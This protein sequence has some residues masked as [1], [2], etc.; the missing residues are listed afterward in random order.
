MKRLTLL[1]PLQ[2]IAIL[3][4]FLALIFYGQDEFFKPKETE[5][6]AGKNLRPNIVTISLES[7]QINGIQTS[8]LAQTHSRLIQLGYGRVLSIDGLLD[9]RTRTLASIAEADVLQAN[10]LHSQQEYQRAS[11]L[12]AENKNV[13]DKAVESALAEMN[14]LK[15]RINTART[16][17]HSMQ[18]S[19]KQAWGEVLTDLAL[20]AAH[21]SHFQHLVNHHL[22]LVLVTLPIDQATHTNLKLSPINNLNTVYTASYLA[23]STITDT[24]LHGK[25]YFYEVRSR[26]L[27]PDMRFYVYTQQAANAHIAIPNQ[28]IV[29]H[30][31]L[32]WVYRQINSTTFVRLHVGKQDT[33][34][35]AANGTFKTGDIV[36]TQGAQLLLSEELK[37]QITNENQD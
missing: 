1:I 28:A 12:N 8:V 11:L 5:H 34:S 13:S 15:Q 17:A 32:A 37:A 26:D 25:T 7:Q 21:D 14:T 29:W 22:A 19:M 35:W 2:T 10:Y 33:D 9:L 24:M 30:D 27:R 6:T 16:L 3:L 23:P 36:V 4:L 31:G 20:N 18:D